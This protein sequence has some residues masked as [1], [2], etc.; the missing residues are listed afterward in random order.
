MYM[1]ES[2]DSSAASTESLERDASSPDYKLYT[3]KQVSLGALCGTV[4][5][6]AILMARNYRAL[7]RPKSAQQS[8]VLGAIGF[9]GV[10]MLALLLPEEVPGVFVYGPAAYVVH[11]VYKNHMQ[12]AYEEHIEQGGEGANTSDVVLLSIGITVA[13]LLLA[14]LSAMALV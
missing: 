6:G 9:V 4:L 5:T 13:L 2:A 12:D 1:P 14:F 8:Y 10:A 11:L 3:I 7:G